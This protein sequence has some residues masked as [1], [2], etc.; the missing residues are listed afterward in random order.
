MS[1]FRDRIANAI[2]RADMEDALPKYID[3]GN[4][5]DLVESLQRPYLQ[6]AQAVIDEF[7]LYVETQSLRWLDPNG[8]FPQTRIVGKWEDA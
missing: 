8:P 1:E 6:L 3:R 4:L 2:F 7:G 5:F